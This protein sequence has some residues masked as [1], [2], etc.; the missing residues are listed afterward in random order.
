VD[1]TVAVSSTVA[2]ARIVPEHLVD[3]DPATAWNSRTG[4]L[5]GAWIAIRLPPAA[6]VDVIKIA[7]GFTQVDKKADLFTMNPRIR[8]VRVSRNGKP[9]LDKQLD[10]E[11]RALQDLPV[12]APGGDFRIEVLEIAPGSRPSWREICVSELEVWGTPPPGT[13]ATRTT[14]TVRVGS[15]DRTTVLGLRRTKD[16][17]TLPLAVATGGWVYLGF[18]DADP[19]SGDLRVESAFHEH[20]GPVIGYDLRRAIDPKALPPRY[21]GAQGMKVAVLD[22][23]FSAKCDGVLETIEVAVEG[24]LDPF[25]S[26]DPSDAERA[27]AQRKIWQPPFA[28]AARLK[29]PCLDRA[30]WARSSELP[31]IA[32]PASEEPPAWLAAAARNAFRELA[33]GSLTKEQAKLARSPLLRYVPAGTG[34]PAY[35]SA[36]V[37]IDLC[38][39]G[40]FGAW[41]LWRVD[42]KQL[43]LVTDA[44]DDL[45]GAVDID[46]DGKDEVITWRGEITGDGYLGWWQD[47]TPFMPAGL[48]CDGHN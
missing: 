19:G 30:A 38:H 44:H 12:D 21:R 11:S 45:A 43:T 9:L 46:G 23:S 2:N 35:V 31:A 7:A 36:S 17:P 37:H 25:P 8:K 15:L 1:S 16:G 26:H 28:I 48:G 3:G 5:V 39:P 42:R 34:H 10:I 29:A 22:A 47:L 33:A 14:P 24:D 27:A 4:D 41:G 20:A 6:H 32:H 18:E 13:P 40:E